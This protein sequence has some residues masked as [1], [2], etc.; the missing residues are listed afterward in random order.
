M[1]GK[2]LLASTLT[3]AKGVGLEH[4]AVMSLVNKYSSKLNKYRLITFEMSKVKAGRPVKFTWLN[5]KQATFLITLMKNS[6]IVVEFKEKLTDEYYRLKETLQTI[7]VNQKNQEWLE[8]RKRGK[9]SRL[10]ETDAIKLYVDYAKSQG[11]KN[12]V[13][14]YMLIS[15]MENKALF[16]LEQKFPNI[17][18]ALEGHQLE[19]IANADRIV[20]RQLKQCVDK[21]KHYKEGYFMAKKAIEAFA[22]LIGKSLVP[23]LELI[24]NRAK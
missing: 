12:A 6:D 3:I 5:E 14:Y 20:A 17:R 23:S 22:E 24:D 10:E 2:E 15:K 8:K 16:F 19:T 21:G 11:S 7:A 9:A 4:R 1:K 18:N 13:K